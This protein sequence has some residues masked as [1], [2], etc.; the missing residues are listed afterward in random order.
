MR[1]ADYS[2]GACFDLALV[3]WVAA[4]AEVPRVVTDIAPVHGLVAEVMAGVAVPD[5]LLPPG[6]T[7][8]DYALRPSDA[9]AM[10]QADLVFWVGEGLTP[11]LARSLENVAPDA[12][13]V[14][15]LATEGTTLLPCAPNIPIPTTSATTRL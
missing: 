1:R 11:W 3:R 12:Q 10:Q 6:T 7:P 15:L 4:Q 9:R 8:H 2:C 13:V 5:L 14:E